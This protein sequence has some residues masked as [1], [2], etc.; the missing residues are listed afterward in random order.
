MSQLPRPRRH[1]RND[2]RAD[3]AY[4]VLDNR[5]IYLGRWNAPDVLDRLLR[6]VDEQEQERQFDAML[7]HADKVLADLEDQ[8]NEDGGP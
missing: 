5:R 3:R 7:D 4:I 8:H 2:G 1:K 6:V